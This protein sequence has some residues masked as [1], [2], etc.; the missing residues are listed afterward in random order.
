MNSTLKRDLEEIQAVQDVC[1]QKGHDRVSSGPTLAAERIGLSAFRVGA[2]Y[3][4][5][6]YAYQ[7]MAKVEKEKKAANRKKRM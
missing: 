4:K 5:M 6:K 7:H 1:I 2:V 3:L